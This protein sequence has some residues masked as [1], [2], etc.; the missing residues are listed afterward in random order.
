M[1]TKTFDCVEMKRR[2]AKKVREAIKGMTVDQEAKFWSKLT[3]ELRRCRKQEQAVDQT[4]TRRT[5]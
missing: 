4:D 1:K 3:T 5:A 2:G